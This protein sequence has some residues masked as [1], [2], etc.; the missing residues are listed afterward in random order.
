MY[1]PNG[2]T[3]RQERFCNEYLKDFNGTQAAIRSGYSEDTA[4]EIASEN[5]TKPNIKARLDELRAIY[6]EN[7]DENWIAREILKIYEMAK[8]SYKLA[9]AQK[10]LE[11]LGKWKA[12][13]TDKQITQTGTIDDLIANNAQN[14][15]R[16]SN[17]APTNPEPVKTDTNHVQQN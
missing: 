16:P 13:F 9:D 8:D 15:G 2:L 5:L 14:N 7:I 11:L 12:M 10:S 6:I 17:V 3:E 1:L 4:K